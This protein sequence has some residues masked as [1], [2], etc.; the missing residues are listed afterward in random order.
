MIRVAILM[1]AV[2]LLFTAEAFGQAPDTWYKVLLKNESLNGPGAEVTTPAAYVGDT[3][4]RTLTVW[5][6]AN[7]IEGDV[8][9]RIRYQFRLK[10]P[11][12][13]PPGLFDWDSL[14][15][16][17]K[18]HMKKTGWAFWRF[19]EP[20]KTKADKVDD[21]DL[22]PGP[23]FKIEAT[24][25]RN[26]EIICLNFTLETDPTPGDRIVSVII[27]DPAES[28][29]ARLQF[30]VPQGPNL[31]RKFSF[32][33]GIP[34]IGPSDIGICQAPLP[35]NLVLKDGAIIRSDVENISDTDR[36]YDIFLGAR[37]AVQPVFDF[38]M[39]GAADSVRFVVNGH[40]QNGN[41]NLTLIVGGKYW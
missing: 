11:E 28:L 6:A 33:P 31:T 16:V 39:P 41:I 13:G 19:L 3:D 14:G 27:E 37:K 2:L 18:D 15:Y 24:D 22:D 40:A 21:D 20:T 9:V 1:I 38:T 32:F 17:L 7:V 4:P 25:T 35:P 30:S 29:F 26:L 36:I 5:T 34:E 8:D 12:G 23:N 10:D